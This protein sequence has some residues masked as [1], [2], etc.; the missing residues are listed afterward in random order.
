MTRL[1]LRKNKLSSELTSTGD[2]VVVAV[3]LFI[4][5]FLVRRLVKVV[6]GRG[7]LLSDVFQ[8][9]RPDF[10]WH[11]LAYDALLL[12]DLQSAGD[13]SGV[14]RLID[15][16]HLGIHRPGR[17]FQCTG[18][19]VLGL[20]VVSVDVVEL[21]LPEG[22]EQGV[23][24]A[25]QE[26]LGEE[27]GVLEVLGLVLGQCSPLGDYIENLTDLF[28]EPDRVEVEVLLQVTLRFFERHFDRLLR[29]E[30]D[31]LAD[32][33]LQVVGLVRLRDRTDDTHVPLRP[34]L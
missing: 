2:V 19:H 24:D 33:G 23:L 12:L 9:R 26:E 16:Q 28:D 27:A 6:H 22:A 20:L 13:V 3:H 7:P 10:D 32:V 31:V 18:H 34:V 17:Q 5:R 1:G 4:V 8:F 21:D 30:L 29:E 14:A 15:A 25:D 11:V